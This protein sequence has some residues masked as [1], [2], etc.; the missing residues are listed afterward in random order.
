MI[1]VGFV[2]VELEAT[3]DLLDRHHQPDDGFFHR[4]QTPGRH[5]RRHPGRFRREPAFELGT[6]CVEV[7]AEFAVGQLSHRAGEMHGLIEPGRHLIRRGIPIG[8]NIGIRAAHGEQPGRF[9]VGQV[10]QRILARDM[11]RRVRRAVIAIAEIKWQRGRDRLAVVAGADRAKAAHVRKR[12]A[13]GSI[14]L[15]ERS[16]KHGLLLSD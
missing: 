13:R 8:R 4:I 5:L 10:H 7:R 15:K 11:K 9:A 6:Q 16:G 3:L 14:G 12:K 2:L 1:D